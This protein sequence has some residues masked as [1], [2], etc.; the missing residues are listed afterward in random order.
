MTTTTSAVP[1][2][3][4]DHPGFS[5][6]TGL[7]AGLSMIAGRDQVARLAIELTQVSAGD[8]VVDVGCGP[9]VAART[10]SKRGADVTG[11]APAGPMLALA[12][13]LSPRNRNITWSE[14]T[15]EQLPLPN[16]SATVIWSLAT[17][18]P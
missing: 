10:A 2:H 13:W 7:L 12:R 9:G 11:I 3:H 16:D 6:I 4:G 15:A 14:G 18:H 1:N 5:G 17:V 8:Q